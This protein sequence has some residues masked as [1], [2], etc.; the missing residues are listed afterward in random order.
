M[1]EVRAML[2]GLA[3]SRQEKAKAW[4][5]HVFTASGMLVGFKALEAAYSGRTYE[6]VLWLILTVLID[7][8][9]G[10]LARRY[11]VNE[12]LPQIDGKMM[13]FVIDFVNFVIT[14]TVV[15]Y[16]NK[17]VPEHVALLTV[18]AIL[19]ASLYH[20][21]NREQVTAD[22][23][24]RGF[25]AFWNLVIY[26]LFILELGQWAN[27][28]IIL[29]IVMLHFSRVKF[30]YISRMQQNRAIAVFVLAV[31]LLSNACLLVA[32]PHTGFVLKL[33][34]VMSL[35]V[36]FALGNLEHELFGAD[37]KIGEQH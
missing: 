21:G 20:Y 15:C 30:L 9:D 27:F 29:V 4:A 8:V 11:H 19:Y 18:A 22:M 12:I 13:D 24:F 28:L 32:Y 2:K 34:A 36:L 16:Q 25:P 33:L 6:T 35:L 3:P 5:V 23:R 14:P 26:Y 7:G 31:L 10:T 1:A 37:T 17:M